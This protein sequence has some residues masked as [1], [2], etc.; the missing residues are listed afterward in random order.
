MGSSQS[1]QSVT[2]TDIE[3][4]INQ[5][6]KNLNTQISDV[7]NQSI[8][9]VSTEMITK[10]ANTI[11][12][13]TSGNNQFTMD[14][15]IVIGG[16][17]KVAIN[18]KVDVQS[19][20][21]AVINLV[22]N[23]KMLSEMA[24][25]TSSDIMNKIGN[26]NA[27][28]AALAAST[29]ISNKKSEEGGV[30]AMADSV[31]KA[32]PG[33]S[34]NS[35]DYTE[36]KIANKLNIDMTNTNFNENKI[37]AIVENNLSTSVKNINAQE[38][39]ID[40]N[41]ENVMRLKGIKVSDDG[42]LQLNQIANVKAFNECVIKTFNTSEMANQISNVQA[43]KTVSIAENKNAASAELT[44]KTKVENE[45]SKTDAFAGMFRGLFG[46][47]FGG[48]F[49]S[50]GSLGPIIIIAVICGLLFFAYKMFSGKKEGSTTSD[51]G[52]GDDKGQDGGSI[53]ICIDTYVVFIFVLVL[54]INYGLG[55]L[56]S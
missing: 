44:A 51:E 50:L 53:N 43:I 2:K 48:S 40:T 35:S 14:G 23:S 12:Q 45:N 56:N 20:N 10:N 32:M 24:S 11:R 34:S 49:G 31:M 25:Q 4:S 8:T 19:T 9:N 46:G 47:L 26:D 41:V 36:T 33:A 37:R 3:N 30:A 1:T 13:S 52:G 38:C 42:Q 27:M 5:K 17:G 29:A 7:M 28:K 15:D 16:K 39:K 18:Q 21:L 6:V 54:Y 22:Q 55:C